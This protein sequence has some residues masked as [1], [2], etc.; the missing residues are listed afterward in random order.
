MKIT[1]RQLRQII[2]EELMR[3][4][5]N[6]ASRGP[7]RGDSFLDHPPED[8]PDM[9]DQYD[10]EYWEGLDDEEPVMSDWGD[11]NEP[12]PDFDDFSYGDDPDEF[13][14]LPAGEIMNRMRR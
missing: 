2:K 14:D 9:G 6:P 10:P 5:S 4:M 11:P 1:Q 7:R 12:D 8:I 3:E 13:M